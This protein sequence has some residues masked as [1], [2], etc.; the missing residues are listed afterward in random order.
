MKTVSQNLN[1]LKIFLLIGFLTTT[2]FQAQEIAMVEKTA[3]INFDKDVID[4]GIIKQNSNGTRIFT[5]TNM[6][7]EP[8]IIT[9]VKTS[10]GC[11]VPTYSKEPILPGQK[12]QIK[13]K[14]DTKRLGAF[15]KTITVSSNAKQ[16]L[17]KLRIKGQVFSRT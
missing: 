11:T 6:G 17:K 16:S 13:I 12:G 8:L 14:Y 5:F 9:K 4:Y 3:I 2:T 7:S 15:S 10:C 1:A